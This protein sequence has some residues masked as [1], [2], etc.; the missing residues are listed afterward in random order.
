MRVGIKEAS[1]TLVRPR[2]RNAISDN[3]QP[4]TGENAL[5]QPDTRCWQ[6]GL[7]SCS[8]ELTGYSKVSYTLGILPDWVRENLRAPGRR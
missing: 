4:T 1:P 8:Q 5:V 2:A 7:P 3:A 6:G